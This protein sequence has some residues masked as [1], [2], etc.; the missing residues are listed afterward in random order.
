[1]ICKACNTE[2]PQE[3]FAKGKVC[4][5]CNN[6]KQRERINA[7]PELQA[8]RRESVRRWR[9]N[10]PEEYQRRQRERHLKYTWGMTTEE[11]DLKLEQQN[12]VCAICGR[13]EKSKRGTASGQLAL[14]VDH[15][16]ETGKIRELLCMDCN[17]TLGKFNDD[18]EWFHKAAEY[19]IKHGKVVGQ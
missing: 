17:Q 15:D 14:A 6:T 5:E 10:N 4:R 3:A 13:P 16:H 11:Y 1:M 9:L 19:L 2:K 18:P 7:S 12:N 8:K